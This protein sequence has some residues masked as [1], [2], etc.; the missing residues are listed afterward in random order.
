MLH[1]D[2]KLSVIVQDGI[3]VSP[4]SFAPFGHRLGSYGYEY[5]SK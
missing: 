4:D 3:H 2:D 5:R 1:F